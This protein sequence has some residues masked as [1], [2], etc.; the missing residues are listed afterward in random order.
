MS[1]NIKETIAEL[2]QQRVKIDMALASLRA[3]NGI[4]PGGTIM[5]A[6]IAHLKEVDVPQSVPE[7]KAALEAQGVHSLSL[8]SL[9]SKRAK[10]KKDLIH[11]GRGL[12]GIKK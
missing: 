3:L 11:K 8:Q 12:W 7:I 5:Q 4:P 6:V 9:L 10:L 1:S 2:E